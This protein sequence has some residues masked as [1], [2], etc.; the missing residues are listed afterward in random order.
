LY[1]PHFRVSYTRGDTIIAT[2]QAIT[3]ATL[4]TG[5]DASA[6]E[7]VT[8]TLTAS[9]VVGL[10]LN[11]TI[12]QTI[13]LIITQGGAG[14]FTLT[15]PGAIKTAWQ[16]AGAVG[17]I[18][19]LK[20]RYYGVNWQ[21]VAGQVAVSDAGVLV[22]PGAAVLGSVTVPPPGGP[23]TAT[24]LP[25]GADYIAAVRI[26][27][28]KPWYDVTH[29]SLGG[30]A[31]PTGV[32][33]SNAAFQAAYNAILAAGGGLL[34]ARGQFKCSINFVLTSNQTWDGLSKDSTYT[35]ANAA[36]LPTG[37]AMLGIP[38]GV[39]RTAIRNLTFDGNRANQT[40]GGPIIDSGNSGVTPTSDI[41]LTDLNL[42]R[43]YQDGCHL[44][45]QRIRLTRVHGEDNG[46][47]GITI[48]YG[49]SDPNNN[50]TGKVTSDVKISQCSGNKHNAVAAGRGMLIIGPGKVGWGTL[51]RDVTITDFHGEQNGQAGVAGGAAIGIVSTN[52]V[53]AET[54]PYNNPAGIA[55]VN[56]KGFTSFGNADS[57]IWL[58]GVRG[59]S[60]TDFAIDA[61]FGGTGIVTLGPGIEVQACSNGTIGKGWVR[62]T[63]WPGI[64]IHSSDNATF[65][66]PTQH[67]TVSQVTLDS[68]GQGDFA[69]AKH[70]GLQIL[71]DNNA[72]LTE[73]IIVDHCIIR[74]SQKQGATVSYCDRVTFDTCNILDNGASGGSG[75]G[76]EFDGRAGAVQP[77]RH[78]VLNCTIGDTRAGGA[79]TQ[80]HGLIDNSSFVAGIEVKNNDLRNN[81]TTPALL[82]DVTGA[83][84]YRGNLGL[85]PKGNMAGWPAFPA[86]TVAYTNNT[87]Y[88][89]IAFCLNGA[90]ALSYTVDATGLPGPIPANA[91]FSVR[92]PAS[93][94]FTPTY[95][96]GAPT[97]TGYGE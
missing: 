17:A 3:E 56:V 54:V 88:D 24:A 38:N 70:E 33:L 68:C 64:W 22:H 57:T 23:Y 52:I 73:D 8:V 40:S 20:L 48:D 60:I 69:A 39:T 15:W 86:T 28:G 32:A 21:Q 31:D 84:V 80:T 71:C 6:G 41:T 90:A 18:S 49:Y 50:T 63:G 92:I 79:R 44:R 81:V 53:G 11:P 45:G 61:N 62:Q 27:G 5:L 25:G 34:L 26:T 30:G 2:V 12:G 96:A 76:I 43:G 36:N 91:A 82:S 77:F 83:N 67:I 59:W 47:Y 51:V 65:Q 10:P 1:D 89:I 19:S 46:L 78:R 87:G 4:V 16:P 29:P 13:E 74:N 95:A 72:W 9:R 94:V 75:Y 97:W 37:T 55:D 42:M 93:S 35:L 85:N 66:L 58:A 7:V 14:N